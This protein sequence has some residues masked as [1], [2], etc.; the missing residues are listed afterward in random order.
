MPL[1][2]KRFPLELGFLINAQSIYCNKYGSLK[3]G[4]FCYYREFD[5][6]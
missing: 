4:P 6:L 5:R 2:N 1:S 3:I